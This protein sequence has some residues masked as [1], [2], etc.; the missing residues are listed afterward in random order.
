MPPHKT[1]L[2]VHAYARP[3][4]ATGREPPSRVAG[5]RDDLK[6][7]LVATLQRLETVGDVVRRADMSNAVMEERVGVLEQERNAAMDTAAAAQERAE[8]L[9][10]SQRRIE[11][12]NKVSTHNGPS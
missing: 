6:A 3:A 7:L 10:K 2:T 1:V 4:I 5:E 8:A 12:Q 11:W 9:L